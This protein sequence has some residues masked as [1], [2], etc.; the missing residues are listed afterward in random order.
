MPCLL[1]STATAMDFVRFIDTGTGVAQRDPLGGVDPA[2][3]SLIYDNATFPSQGGRTLLVSFPRFGSDQIGDDIILSSQTPGFLTDGL[4]AFRNMSTSRSLT[5]FT[6]VH[7]WYN[8]TRQ[9]LAERTSSLSL[10]GGLPPL[11]AAQIESQ[12]NLLLPYNIPVHGS[13]HWSLQF[14]DIQGIF[15][16]DLAFVVAGPH[17]LGSSTSLI[18]NYTTGTDIDLGANGDANLMFKL[19]STTPTPSTISLGLL[20]TFIACRRR[21]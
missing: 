7:R 19:S 18:H 16:S 12:G 9:L 6:V 8:D 13:V 5:S 1:C 4:Y 21:R 17:T 3:G 10:G 20:S 15:L 14:S 2:D 11:A